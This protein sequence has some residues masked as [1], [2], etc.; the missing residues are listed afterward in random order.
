LDREIVIA[1]ELGEAHELVEPLLGD[2]PVAGGIG[3][4]TMCRAGRLAVDGD[5][6]ADRAAVRRRAEHEVNVACAETV[7]NACAGLV[8]PRILLRD[9]PLAD[10]APLAGRRETGGVFDA[11]I[12]ALGRL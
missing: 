1:G 12:A 10:E 2:D 9:G 3:I 11:P 8:G 4:E 7:E 5:P 6:E